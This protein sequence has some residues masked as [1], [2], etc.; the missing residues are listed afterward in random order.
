M[1]LSCFIIDDHDFAIE[2]LSKLIRQTPGL[3]YL[4]ASMESEEAIKR[5]LSGELRPD[6]IFLDIS[7]PKQSGFDVASIIGNRT[8]I[9]F[10]TAYRQYGA[11]SYDYAAVDYLLKPV[12]PDRFLKAVEKAKEL[13]QF[14]ILSK[15]YISFPQGRNKYFKICLYDIVLVEC[16]KN[17]LYLYTND[18]DRHMLHMSMRRM[19]TLLQSPRLIRIHKSFIINLDMIKSVDGPSIMMSNGIEVKVGTT[20]RDKLNYIYDHAV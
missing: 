14:W 17:Y 13:Y 8:M 10:T 18:G 15:K 19:E 1:T 16:A 9:I 3:T 12:M 4:G 7:M 20:Y 2:L 11:D 5:I 6:L